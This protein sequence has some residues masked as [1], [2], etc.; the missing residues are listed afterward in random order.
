MLP[1]RRVWLLSSGHPCQV[2]VIF[3]LILKRNSPQ[4]C[5][6]PSNST[7]QS[8]RITATFA[9]KSRARCCS[10]HGSIAFYALYS[11]YHWRSSYTN[12]PGYR[13]TLVNL[14]KL[15]T[16]SDLVS[17]SFRLWNEAQ[18]WALSGGFYQKA[19]EFFFDTSGSSVMS[20][21][22]VVNKCYEKEFRRNI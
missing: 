14:E 9:V 7:S 22:Y 1:W 20:V 19:P 15:S 12:P 17:R 13:C 2:H 21:S 10:K 4:E 11:R 8:H 3:V 5:A 16:N 18:R 6:L